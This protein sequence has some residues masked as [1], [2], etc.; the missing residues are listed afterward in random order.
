ML[1][2]TGHES[3]PMPHN[4]PVNARKPDHEETHDEWFLRKAQEGLDRAN[5]PGAE[6]FTHEE[7]LKRSEARRAKILA[8]MAKG[9]SG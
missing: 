2:A 4:A 8:R 6:W 7:A 3:N 9:K 1:N 5:D